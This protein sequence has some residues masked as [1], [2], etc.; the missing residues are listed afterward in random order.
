MLPILAALLLPILK[1]DQSMV[2][3]SN[4]EEYFTRKRVE[5]ALIKEKDAA[6]NELR[7]Q[8]AQAVAE[9]IGITDVELAGRLVDLGFGADMVGIFS[10]LPLVY[11]A[12]ADGDVSNAE[13]NKILSVAEARGAAIDSDGYKFLESLLER[14]PSAGFLTTCLDTL[15]AIYAALPEGDA[16]NARQDLVSLSLSVAGASGGF[17]GIFGNKVSAEEKALIDEIVKELNLA[18][19]DEAAKLLEAIQD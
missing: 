1:G 19:S 8:E 12:W 18:K 5:D 4:E 11:V 3:K 14:K 7:Q 16:E 17:L 10:L 9:R 13:R 2:P 6:V 15:R